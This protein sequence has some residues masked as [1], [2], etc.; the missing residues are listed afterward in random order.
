MIQVPEPDYP[1]TS[2]CPRPLTM[3][4]YY[5]SKTTACSKRWVMRVRNKAFCQ[6]FRSTG[7]HSMASQSRYYLTTEHRSGDRPREMRLG[8]IAHRHLRACPVT[9][10]ATKPGTHRIRSTTNTQTGMQPATAEPTPGRRLF[11]FSP[12][13]SYRHNLKLSL[14]TVSS[15]SLVLELTGE[16]KGSIRSI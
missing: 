1:N 15:S 12:F 3:G 5:C 13:K 16:R 11:S 7:A 2:H 14:T 6:P 4:D 10:H 8:D 9:N